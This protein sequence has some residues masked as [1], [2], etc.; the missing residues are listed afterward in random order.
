[1]YLGAIGQTLVFEQGLTSSKLALLCIG[2]IA[3]VVAVY[4]MTR[5]V[6]QKLREMT[7]AQE[8]IGLRP[9]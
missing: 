8:T 5:K 3:T 2:L 7:T 1:V 9:S 6:S 4:M